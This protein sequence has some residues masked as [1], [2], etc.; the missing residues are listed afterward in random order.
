MAT[1]IDHPTIDH[2]TGGFAGLRV[3]SLE[4]RRASEMAKLI[5]SHGGVATVAPSMREVPLESNAEAQEFVRTLVAGGFDVVIFLTGVGA[6]ALA[7]VVETVLPMEK[8][9]ASLRKIPVIARGPKPVVVL[10]ELGIPI[11]LAV[12]ELQYLAGTSASPRQ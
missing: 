1:E 5:A 4:S 8:F 9:V 7:R 3:L 11:A 2:P 6:R 10:R 12:P